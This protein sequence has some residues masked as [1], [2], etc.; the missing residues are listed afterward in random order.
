MP[1]LIEHYNPSFPVNMQ[2][3]YC[4]SERIKPRSIRNILVLKLDHIGETSKL[5][6]TAQLCLLVDAIPTGLSSSV[7]S[8]F[9]RKRAITF[10]E[11]VLDKEREL[12][13]LSKY[14]GV[15]KNEF[16]IGMH[17]GVGNPIR[18][19]PI[20][21]FARLA[22][23]LVEKYAAQIIL[24]GGAEERHLTS[25]LYNFIKEKQKVTSLIGKT[26]LEEYMFLIRKCHALIGNMSGL[27]HIAA[28]LGVPTLTIVGGQV[29]P[30]E[31]HPLGRRS[32]SVRLKVDCAP[33]YKSGIGE[34]PYGIKC[35]ASLSPEGV[36]TATRQL[37]QMIKKP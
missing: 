22:N 15:F 9:R 17:P 29:L 25:D 11:I 18:E 32:L 30:Q 7:L 16:L 19:W 27:S 4:K 33:C 28:L 26:S 10:P 23:L 24:F 1:V 3:E 14:P 12:N 6:T 2:I 20:A 5:H 13:A 21:Y 37:L 8:I 35:L 34:C 36:F 31:W